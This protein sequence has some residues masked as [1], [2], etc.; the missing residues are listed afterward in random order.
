MLGENTLIDLGDLTVL[1]VIAAKVAAKT[2]YG[3]DRGPWM[4][5]IKR[6]LLH[7]IRGD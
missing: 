2:A 1:T 5:V 6:L 3:E 7:G 4:K